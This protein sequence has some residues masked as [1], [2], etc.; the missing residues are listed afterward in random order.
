MLELIFAILGAL[1]L[2]TV[3]ILAVRAVNSRRRADRG[4]NVPTDGDYIGGGGRSRGD[5][6]GSGYF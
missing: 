6:I 3:G 5:Y 2:I 4:I 1:L